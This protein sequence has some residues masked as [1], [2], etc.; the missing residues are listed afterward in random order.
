MNKEKK[1]LQELYAW[2]DFYV[3]NE[4][5]ENAYKIQEQIT[6]QKKKV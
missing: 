1:K 3:Q 2:S 6:E 5:H 4:Q